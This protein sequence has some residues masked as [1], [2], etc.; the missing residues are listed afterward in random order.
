MS[1]CSTTK[2]MT[3][4]DFGVICNNYYTD[5]KPEGFKLATSESD[6]ALTSTSFSEFKNFDQRHTDQVND[7]QGK[8]SKFFFHYM[9]DS[10][11]MLVKVALVYTNEKGNGI[12]YVSTISGDD[13]VALNTN[14]T[15]YFRP[16][17]ELMIVE[18]VG[19]CV[20]I[21]AIGVADNAS[22]LKNNLDESFINNW[23]KFTQSLDSEILEL[24]KIQN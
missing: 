11:T 4:D 15:A 14:Y 10:N 1:A 7:E 12:R 6:L 24:E 8:P 3:Y 21:Q 18:R 16:T 2:V 5:F 19:Y 13:V 20:I 22:K 23:V 9:D 17:S